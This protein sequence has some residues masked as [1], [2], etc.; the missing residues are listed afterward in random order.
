MSNEEPG[1]LL[2]LLDGKVGMSNEESG[3][4]LLRSLLN[5]YRS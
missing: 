4:L 2:L 3:E 5:C 1:E